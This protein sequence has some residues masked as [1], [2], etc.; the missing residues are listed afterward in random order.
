MR[1]RGK[2]SVKVAS[3]ALVRDG[4]CVR[5]CV[6][7]IASCAAPSCRVA[8]FRRVQARARRRRGTVNVDLS[9]PSATSLRPARP[10]A[11]KR[12]HARDGTE[13]L[14]RAG[15]RAILD[16]PYGLSRTTYRRS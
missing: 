7:R 12:D 1:A 11:T 9:P 16:F 6:H 10:R 3:F 15:R 2:E 8:S 5:V 14:F 4:I 13:S